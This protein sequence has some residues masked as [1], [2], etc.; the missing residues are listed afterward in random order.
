VYETVNLHKIKTYTPNLVIINLWGVAFI[1][2]E[3]V[4]SLSASFAKLECL[5]VNYC[6][7]V[8]WGKGMGVGEGRCLGEF[9]CIDGE[10]SEY[11]RTHCRRKRNTFNFKTLKIFLRVHT[12]VKRPKDQNTTLQVTGTSFKNIA[13]RCKQLTALLCAHT[14]L[15]SAAIIDVPWET[16]KIDELDVSATE[17]TSEALSKMLTRL[18]L[19]RW[20]KAAFLEYFNDEV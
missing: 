3:H 4:D 17:L 6:H 8:W 13:T 10:L 7:K 5:A 12:S 18:P 15:N 9:Q 11:C 16:T 14:N 19:L 2:D 20:L 1:T